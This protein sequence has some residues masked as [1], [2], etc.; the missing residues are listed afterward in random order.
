MLSSER[1]VINC[2]SVNRFYKDLS[3][4]NAYLIL[5]EYFY[6]VLPNLN[7]FV[8]GQISAIPINTIEV[9]CSDIFPEIMTNFELEPE[10]VV[11][12]CSLKKVFLEISQN[13]QENACARVSLFKTLTL[14]FSC[15][16]CKI[17]KND[18]TLINFMVTLFIRCKFK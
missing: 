14:V 18:N 4:K 15:E 10:A 17:S 8:A 3:Y 5:S 2:I 1:L 11:R 7:E 12:R 13:S 6:Y 16:F 9:H